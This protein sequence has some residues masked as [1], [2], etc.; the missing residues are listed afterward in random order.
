[1]LT[2]DKYVIVRRGPFSK[3]S[4]LILMS[5][6]FRWL[7]SASGATHFLSED[8]AKLV[9]ETIIKYKDYVSEF[10]NDCAEQEGI[11]YDVEKF[12]RVIYV[13]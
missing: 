12:K 10:Q 7:F 13:R 3:V 11:Y 4:Y 5:D 6:R 1:M 8:D 2:M 9:L